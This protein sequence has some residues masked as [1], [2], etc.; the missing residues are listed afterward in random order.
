MTTGEGVNGRCR[1]EGWKI[2]CLSSFLP[3]SLS[4]RSLTLKERR[5]MGRWLHREQGPPTRL[6]TEREGA[7]RKERLG[8]RVGPGS[9][10]PHPASRF[11]RVQDGRQMATCNSIPTPGTASA[12]FAPQVVLS[13]NMIS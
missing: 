7:K 8:G 11:R 9:V 4:S 3:P 2:H 1:A 12:G 13:G 10:A 6:H 5:R